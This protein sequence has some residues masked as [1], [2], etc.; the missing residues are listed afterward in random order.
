M[1]PTFGSRRT[2]HGLGLEIEWLGNRL[3]FRPESPSRSCR[4][5]GGW[6]I[7]SSG[8]ST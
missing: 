7:Q 1:R 4:W 2:V 5:N 6:L 8:H 3:N